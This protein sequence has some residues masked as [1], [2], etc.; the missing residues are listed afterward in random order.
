MGLPQ[1]VYWLCDLLMFRLLGWR[2]EGQLPQV[3][4][5][6]AIGA[7]HTSNWDF[8]IG[9]AAYHRLKIQFRWYGKHTIFIWPVGVLLRA[10]GGFPIERAHHHDVVSVA[11]AKFKR[12]DH[13]IL[14][15]APEG[16]RGKVDKWKTGF[17]HIALGAGVPICPFAL[18]F[19]HKRVVCGQL[20]YP[21]GDKEKD[22]AHLQDFFRQFRGRHPELGFPPPNH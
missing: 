14:A 20:F 17:Y 13:F 10:M 3:P 1:L 8:F 4:K 5:Y 2:V 11:I 6:V 9:M 16:T 21:T 22:I 19:E 15:L 12:E 7:P 18:D